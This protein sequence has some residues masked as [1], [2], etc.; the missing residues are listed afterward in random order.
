[1]LRA[2][3]LFSFPI[4]HLTNNGY[5]RQSKNTEAYNTSRPWHCD[6]RA[7]RDNGGIGILQSA[8]AAGEA[9]Q[10]KLRNAIRS[11]LPC[12]QGLLGDSQLAI[13][14]LQKLLP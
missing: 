8:F 14:R 10:M 3:S 1:M 6:E 7:L 2:S 5:N 12:L 11:E 9:S 4:H 13:T